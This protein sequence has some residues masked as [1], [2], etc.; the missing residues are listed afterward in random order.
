MLV[1]LAK[2]PLYRPR[3][4]RRFGTTSSKWQMALPDVMSTLEKFHFNQAS[5]SIAEINTSLG[6]MEN[7]K[8]CLN[9]WIDGF[10]RKIS[11]QMVFSN[12]R[13]FNGDIVQ[14]I[15]RMES[16]SEGMR[17]FKPEDCITVS[18]SVS[19]RKNKDGSDS[20]ELVMD[21]Y[22]LLNKSTEKASQLESGK[23]ETGTYPPEYRY[24]Q[25]RTP[26]Y[27][28]AMKMRAQAARVARRVL[29]SKGF[30]EIETPLLFKSTPEGAKEFLVP[31]RR[32]GLFYALPQSPQQYKQMLMASGFKGYYQLAKCFR[33][34][35]LRADRQPEFT[36]IDMEMAFAAHSHVQKVVQDVVSSIWKEVRGLPLYKVDW[37]TGLLVQLE[38]GEAFP[39]LEYETALR[40]FGIDKPD[41]RSMLEFVDISTD[42]MSAFREGFDVVEACVLKGA[43]VR[44]DGS[45]GSKF[46]S[47]LVDANE[48]KG[49]RPY[50]FKITNAEQLAQWATKLPLELKGDTA[51]LNGKLKLEIGDVVAVSDR[52]TMA[53]ENPTPLGRFR[54]VATE[55]YPTS[56]RREIQQGSTPQTNA[57]IFVASWVMDFP[58]FSPIELD[59]V[60]GYP[61][62]DFGKFESTHHPFTMSRLADYP[63]LATAPLEVKGDHYDLVI[64]GTEVGG[65][66]RRVHDADVQA[67]IFAEILKITNYKDL[68]G[69]L[70]HVLA[71]G[72]PPHA[73]L[74]IGFDRMCSMLLGSSNIRDV[75]AFPKNQ[76]GTDPVV[77]SPS[78][79]P[80]KTLDIYGLQVASATP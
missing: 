70:L 66:S 23:Q 33:D 40:K 14:I 12:F 53:Y 21:K 13:D 34:E 42:F 71:N 54:Q 19:R 57:D 44:P 27:Q 73:G 67:Y 36:Q 69:H 8:V 62:Y 56:W 78:S 63:L 28:K 43:L 9:G 64:N 3:T 41:L 38:E 30:T 68:F 24:L 4:L 55:A 39:T 7:Q 65:G 11:K 10:P 5:H 18:G 20:W 29:D 52:A 25:L 1:R 59:P 47:R 72:C 76:A 17:Q 75:V 37:S 6:E 31:T 46:D 79:V 2:Q 60:D 74:A 26:Y 45:I 58:L 16:L 80:Q 61:V 48:Y 50:V 15:S 22:E 35:D 77:E 49:R 51:A 32:K